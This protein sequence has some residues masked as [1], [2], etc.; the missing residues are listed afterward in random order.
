MAYLIVII[1]IVFLLVV[2][3]LVYKF[4]W[5][6]YAIFFW[7]AIYVP[8]TEKRVE[9]MLSFL[10]LDKAK[11]AVDLGAGDGRL[12]IALAKEG[13]ESCGFE[14]NPFLVSLAQKNIKKAGLENK[15]SVQLKNLWNENLEDFDVVVLY[16]MRHMMKK[17][18]EKMNNELKPG[19]VV[20][21]NCFAF[22]N[23]ICSKKMDG[24]YLYVKE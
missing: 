4:I 17:L 5:F 10:D 3:F 19:A 11:R 12:V 20:V 18:E 8:T 2:L 16:G 15:A 21:S 6:A 14:I 23:W 9:Q 1:F 24:I 13:I 22:P 7:G